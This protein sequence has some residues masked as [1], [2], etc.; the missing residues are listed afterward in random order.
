MKCVRK[1]EGKKKYTFFLSVFSW[2][3]SGAWFMPQWTF[4]KPCMHFEGEKKKLC[5][6]MS[7]DWGKWVVWLF[8]GVLHCAV[9]STLWS[10]CICK[11][12]LILF[13]GA[14]CFWGQFNKKKT[15]IYNIFLWYCGLFLWASPISSSVH[16][17]VITTMYL[18][19]LLDPDV[20]WTA[21]TDRWNTGLP[22]QAYTL[23]VQ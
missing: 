19:M 6:V 3:A 2:H 13:H 12:I 18:Q 10:D 11:C 8:W 1:L 7:C 22:K 4:L 9:W 16:V 21:Q 5:T 20:V 15:V 17:R 14:T 23:H